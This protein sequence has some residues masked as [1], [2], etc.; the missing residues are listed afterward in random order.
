[1]FSA[2]LNK[3]DKANN[4]DAFY[5]SMALGRGLGKKINRNEIKNFGDLCYNLYLA[6]AKE[7]NSFDLFQLA[8]ISNFLC[9]PEITESIPDEFWI[10]SLEPALEEALANFIKYGD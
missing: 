2:V 4:K 10:E 1:M 6:T 3:I 7:I 5:L 9:S 8:Q